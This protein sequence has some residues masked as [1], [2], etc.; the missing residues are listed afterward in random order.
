MTERGAH[1][2]ILVLVSAIVIGLAGCESSRPAPP[3]VISYEA[4]GELRGIWTGT[5]G[6]TPLTLSIVDE[7]E[8][9]PYS[10]L[11]FGPWLIAGQRYA[12][13][14]GIVTYSSDGSPSSAQF[15]GWI[16]SL[17]PFTAFILAEP[18]AGQLDLRLKGAGPGRLAGEGRSTFRWGP[19]G[20]IELTRR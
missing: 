14:S 10:G 17:R 2:A 15:T 9:A 18:P 12:G 6:G 7:N 11:Y 3:P 5:W 19:R 8:S 20:S 13:I 4:I 1:R 16:Y